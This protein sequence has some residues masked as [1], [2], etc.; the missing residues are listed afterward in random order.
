MGQARAVIGDAEKLVHDGSAVDFPAPNKYVAPIAF[1]VLPLAGSIVD[2]GS[3]E[4]DED[5]KLRNESRKI[6]GLPD[7]LVSARAS[8]S[9]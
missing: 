4:T 5:Q 9:P 3:G 7:L 1:N 2:D 8:A 6:L